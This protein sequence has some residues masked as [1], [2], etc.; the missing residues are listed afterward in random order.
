VAK[1][2]LDR[3]V[4]AFGSTDAGDGLTVTLHGHTFRY[5]APDADPQAEERQMLAVER[6][7]KRA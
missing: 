3:R 6:F 2:D 7:A 1:D 5:V 4:P